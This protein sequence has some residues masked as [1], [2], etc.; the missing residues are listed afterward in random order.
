MVVDG[1]VFVSYAA[2]LVDLGFCLPFSS[3]GSLIPENAALFQCS[4]C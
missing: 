4:G 1:K 3:F 2:W